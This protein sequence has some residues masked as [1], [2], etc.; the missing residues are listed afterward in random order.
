MRNKR[1]ERFRRFR[2]NLKKKIIRKSI[3]RSGEKSRKKSA[4]R[5]EEKSVRKSEI[6]ISS[7]KSDKK[8]EKMDKKIDLVENSGT[9]NSKKVEN[10]RTGNLKKIENSRTGN[11]KKIENS[12]TSNSKKVENSRT[13]NLI[14]IDV[15]PKNTSSLTNE[16]MTKK[17]KS[18]R[19]GFD[20]IRENQNVN[21]TDQ[22]KM[23]NVP[24]ELKHSILNL[25]DQITEANQ[26]NQ[27]ETVKN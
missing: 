17:V 16:K 20:E 1:R 3:K 14:K 19:L 13:G 22:N 15:E 10:S 18:E 24:D 11:S 6:K 21:N 5:S 27:D 8:I 7:A 12:R 4:R 23:N 26:T 9:G 25:N 2:S